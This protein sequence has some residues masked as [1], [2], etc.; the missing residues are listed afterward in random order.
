MAYN[1]QKL[2][3]IVKHISSEN[4]SQEIVVRRE[5]SRYHA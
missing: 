5:Y 1:F 4:N 3:F 2:I